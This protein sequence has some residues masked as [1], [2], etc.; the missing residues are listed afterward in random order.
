MRA[1]EI[2]GVLE[3]KMWIYTGHRPSRLN[4]EGDIEHMAPVDR[5]K[6]GPFWVRTNFQE[7]AR[8]KFFKRIDAMPWVE[9]KKPEVFKQWRRIWLGP[10]ANHSL[11][12]SDKKPSKMTGHAIEC[13]DVSVLNGMVTAKQPIYS[14]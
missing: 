13:Q 7:E 12:W 3:G 5:S 14:E 6:K 1:F 8:E 11:G 10:D 4:K 9:P 2:P